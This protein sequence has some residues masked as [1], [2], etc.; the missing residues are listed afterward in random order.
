MK[1]KTISG[2]VVSFILVIFLT[3]GCATH[4][5]K[6]ASAAQPATIKFSKF[7]KFEIAP[8]TISP[9]FA[10][11]SANKK[12]AKKIEENIFACMSMCLTDLKKI[13][14]GKAKVGPGASGL[15]IQPEIKEIKFIGG[16][17]R[18][19]V[20]PMAGSSAV[21]MKTKYIDKK[22]GK[23]IAEPEFY[24]AANAFGGGFSMGA[25]DNMMLDT[26]AQDIC[27]YTSNNR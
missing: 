2:I 10:S 11:Q 16:A 12:A 23:I 7:S 13:E 6:P 14:E 27:R 5:N 9:K 19:W 20:G 1:K 21:L 4:I 26:I 18:F 15:L 22:T 24:R 17:A 8:V 25:T 3:Q